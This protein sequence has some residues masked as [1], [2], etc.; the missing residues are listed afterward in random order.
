MVYGILMGNSC[1]SLGTRWSGLLIRKL[2]AVAV[3]CI[4]GMHILKLLVRL[5][6]PPVKVPAR[7]ASVPV[8]VDVLQDGRGAVV[9]PALLQR[10]GRLDAGPAGQP[11]HPGRHPAWC[12]GSCWR[13]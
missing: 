1:W 8:R 10:H 5:I 9:Q 4:K 6:A 7:A 13:F 3:A 12:A 2:P 11:E